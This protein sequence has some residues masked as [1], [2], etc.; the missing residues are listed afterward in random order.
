MACNA[1]F[2]SVAADWVEMSS[3]Q[4]QDGQMTLSHGK[5]N[6]M[7]GR[8]FGNCTSPSLRHVTSRNALS[9]IPHI[10]DG[11]DHFRLDEVTCQREGYV[12]FRQFLPYI[13]IILNISCN[14]VIRSLT[15]KIANKYRFFASFIHSVTSLRISTK[16][17]SFTCLVMMSLVVTSTAY[18]QVVSPPQHL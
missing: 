10:P 14:D 13:P 4:A 18:P 3:P 15:A 11:S 6:G 2:S 1:F 9:Y 7:D 5:L 12:L 16:M 17:L 8:K